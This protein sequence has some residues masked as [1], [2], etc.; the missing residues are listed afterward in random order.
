M[1][2]ANRTNEA[3]EGKPNAGCTRRS[4]LKDMGLAGAAAMGATALAGC[5]PSGGSAEATSASAEVPAVTQRLLERGVLGANLP[6]AAPIMPVDPPEQWDD[7]A[8]LIVV[9]LGGGGLAA[10]GYAAEQGLKVIALEKEATVGGAGR[11]AAGYVDILGGAE[12]QKALHFPGVY[13]GDDAA[14]IRDA[15][16][17]ANYSIDERFLRTLIDNHVE[18]NEWITASE[19]CNLVCTGAAWNDASRMGGGGTQYNVLAQ[20]NLMNA[21]EQRAVKGGVDIR[22]NT[23]ASTFVFDGKR[24]VGIVVVDGSG[25]EHYLKAK[26][27]LVLTAGGMGMNKDLIKAYIPSAYEGAVQGGPMPFHTGEVFRMGLGVGADFS[28]FDSWCCWEGGI[29]ESIAGGDGQFWHYFWHGERQLFHNP[30]L[31]ID[32]YGHR[33]PYHAQNVQAD[34]YNTCLIGGM[35]DL[36]TTS[37]WMSAVGHHVYNI[38]DAKFPDEI[39]KKNVT[40]EGIKDQCRIP[41]SDPAL[42]PDT[43]G[44]VTADWVGEVED[45]V[46]RG[47]VK[48]A[49]TL[50]KLAEMLLLDPEVVKGAVKEYNALCE[51]GVDDELAI[52]YDPSWL[53]PIDTPPYYA[54]IVG[55]QIGKTLCGLRVN[56]NLQVTNEDGVAIEGLYA[57]FSTLGGMDGEGNYGCLAGNGGTYFGGVGSSLITGYIAA[58]KLMELEA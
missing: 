14:A 47:A 55:G 1:N 43:K 5:A 39:F 44:L 4:F 17:T 3:L 50:E 19:G 46:A 18:A 35:G 2:G 12:A 53:S 30:W 52:P 21:L 38:C 22:T 37:A 42:L 26:K 41:L 56:D 40:P 23:A 51:K 24:V 45:A 20:D 48:K 34:T 49:E 32:K 11:H 9:G 28:G 54:A 7:E 57:G 58:K 27:G 25:T 36:S 29:D 13:G 15:E 31:V 10:A 33:Q 16:Q 6:D 8:D